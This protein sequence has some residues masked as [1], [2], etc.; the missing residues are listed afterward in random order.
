MERIKR[1]ADQIHRELC[2]AE[3]Y[4]ECHIQAKADGDYAWAEKVKLM[5]EDEV[6]HATVLH[7]RAVAEIEKLE[8]H[9]NPT[10]EMKDGWDKAHREY[11][12]KH[13]WIEELLGVG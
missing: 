8:E 13:E 9:Y 4:A 12:R 7:D 1:I 3:Y 5:A 11:I 2:C 10:S 6:R